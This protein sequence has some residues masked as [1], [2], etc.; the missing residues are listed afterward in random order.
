MAS[1]L[2][3]PREVYLEG[4]NL[5]RT[6]EAARW[7][8]DLAP[9]MRE[10]AE[11]L[12]RAFRE[13]LANPRID[14]ATGEV[15]DVDRPRGSLGA[16]SAET[17]AALV[18]VDRRIQAK[19]GNLTGST[20]GRA[21]LY[22]QGATFQGADTGAQL[23]RLG[24]A[25]NRVFTARALRTWRRQD[26]WERARV[27]AMVRKEHGRQFTEAQARRG[28]VASALAG[29]GAPAQAERLTILQQQVT[30]ISTR[31]PVPFSKNAVVELVNL[32]GADEFKALG[33]THVLITDGPECGWTEHD[34]PDLA[35]G[36][37]RTVEE[38]AAYPYSHPNCRRLATPQRPR[39]R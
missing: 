38:Y 19:V 2:T 8:N 10:R 24:R 29:Q 5:M 11:L 17:R 22:Y 7:Q 13:A 27:A 18:E 36:S 6:R 35:A 4:L 23:G 1:A 14:P 31:T 33:I 16:A 39:S 32:T 25:P 28:R 21:R 34:D 12:Q 9:L 30:N 20:V 37:R 15:L 3:V 26:R